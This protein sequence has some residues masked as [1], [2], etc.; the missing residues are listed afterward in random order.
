MNVT[1]IKGFRDVL[2]AEAARRRAIVDA[3]RTALEPYGY[4]EIELP[5]VEKGELFQRSVGATSDIVEKEMYSFE[6]RDGTLIALR[7]EGTASAVRAYIE[8]GLTRS[9]PVGRLWYSGP[10][11]RRERPQKGRYR[12]FSQIGAEFFGRDDAAADAETLCLVADICAAVGVRGTRIDLNSLGDATCRPAYREALSRYG[13]AHAADL[14]ADC[15]ARLERN[16]LRLLDCKNEGCKAAMQAAPLMI[17]HL[18]DPCR[19]HHDEVL[20]LLG[21]AAVE[22]SANPRMVRGLD[23][24]CRTAFEVVAGGLGAQDAVGGGGRYDGL[25]A[26][27]GGPEMAGIGFA[28]GLERLDLASRQPQSAQDGPTQDAKDEAAGRVEILLAPIGEVAA[29]PALA[30]ARRLRQTGCRI[31]VE[32]PGRRLKAQMKH[33]DKIGAR[34][35]VIVGDAEIATGRATVRDMRA[36]R[37]HAS[38]FGLND[39]AGEIVT[40]LERIGQFE[41]R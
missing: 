11:F 31:E 6:D 27:L 34:F 39:A 19:A 22:V 40:T 37:D 30:L 24:Y 21:A 25:V 33:A 28:F 10:M 3:A 8:N 36:Q 38:A 2:P 20:R 17:D 26:A 29:G 35:V 18:C 5:L 4:A 7:P 15:R 13:S 32:S 41:Q 1:S 12:Q 9:L 14:C 16:P 23:Y